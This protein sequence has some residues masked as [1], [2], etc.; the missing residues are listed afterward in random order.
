MDKSQLYK[1]FL[2]F[3]GGESIEIEGLYLKP[4]RILRDNNTIEFSIQNPNDISYYL[5]AI[6]EYLNDILFD[7]GKFT[8]SLFKIH[9]DTN[10]HVIYFNKKLKNDISKVL[11]SIKTL[12]LS[13]SSGNDM[14]NTEITGRSIDFN[15]ELGDDSIYIWNEFDA[16]SGIVYSE[17]HGTKFTSNL[18]KCIDYYFQTIESNSRYLE[19]EEVYQEL[20]VV[21]A[22]YPLI[23][24]WLT[25]IYHTSFKNLS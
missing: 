14:I 12:K 20:D 24:S 2:N 17:N 6:E 7:F 8:N 23:P 22:D 21:L 15:V 18:E 16:E 11:K 4:E 1:L 13:N 10:Y 25:Q 19:S 9:V 3:I 5:G